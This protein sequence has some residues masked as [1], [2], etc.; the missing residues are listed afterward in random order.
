MPASLCISLSC[1][2][3]NITKAFNS[4][5]L[6]YRLD[7]R[8]GASGTNATVEESNIMAQGSS[9]SISVLGDQKMRS[10]SI[11]QARTKDGSEIS[12]SKLKT[13]TISK[14]N[15]FALQDKVI[16][17]LLWVSATLIDEWYCNFSRRK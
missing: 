7:N 12:S 17:I 5:V 15:A 6:F 4:L 1:R 13:E 16:F 8:K 11:P 9:P 2:L 10:D 3:F 14:K